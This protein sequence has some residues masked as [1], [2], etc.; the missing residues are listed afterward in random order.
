[1]KVFDTFNWKC[2]LITAAGIYFVQSLL[3]VYVTP[4]LYFA[5]S[6][7][8]ERAA[9]EMGLWRLSGAIICDA[10]MFWMQWAA[11][12]LHCYEFPMGQPPPRAPWDADRP[13]CY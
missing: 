9:K 6:G 5:P 12:G 3:L 4:A 10:N 1:M 7:R 11:F 13:R 8:L 2:F